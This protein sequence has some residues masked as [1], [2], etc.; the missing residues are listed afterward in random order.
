MGSIIHSIME[1]RKEREH[2]ISMGIKHVEDR[3][4]EC[5]KTEHVRAV[6]CLLESISA[7][8]GTKSCL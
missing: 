3:L 4:I 1:E 5:A 8:H 7:V 2:V 6:W